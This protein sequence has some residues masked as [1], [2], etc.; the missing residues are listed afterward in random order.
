MSVVAV[1]SRF[2]HAVALF[3]VNHRCLIT[4][5]PRC[6]PFPRQPPQFSPVSAT[7]WPF[8]VSTTT[9]L[10][11]FCHASAAFRVSCRSFLPFLPRFRCFSCQPPQFSP[12]SAT[13]WP[14]FVS[15]TAVFFRFCHASAA[16]R[17]NHHCLKT[18]LPRCGPFPCQPPQF[19]PVS[20]TLPL[21]FV[22]GTA[23]WV[24][25]FSHKRPRHP[26]HPRQWARCRNKP[27]T[28]PV[29]VPHRAFCVIS[30][31]KVPPE[32]HTPPASFSARPPPSVPCAPQ[33]L[34]R[35]I[36]GQGPPETH[37][38]PASFSARPPPPRPPNYI[39]GIFR[40]SWLFS[41]K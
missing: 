5:L 25:V 8:S 16:F 26:R 28:L 38:P 34:L 3:R 19:S 15:T 20:A 18:F 9:V 10:E 29:H 6:G 1:F 27:D 30:S 23:V 4:F 14:F 24:R 39:L 13:L 12:V 33:G 40:V 22:S 21:L 31:G 41:G 2:C 17:V 35:H 11:R 7:L 32:T 36:A 37:T